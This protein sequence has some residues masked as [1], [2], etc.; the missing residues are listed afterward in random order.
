[1]GL[2]LM[3]MM[4]DAEK[5]WVI[6][7]IGSITASNGEVYIKEMYKNILTKEFPHQTI[8]RQ[9]CKIKKKD[10]EQ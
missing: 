5:K 10:L 9:L 4:T 3:N 1:M 2:D 6:E 8:V 7:Q